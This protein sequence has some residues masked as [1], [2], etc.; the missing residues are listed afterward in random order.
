M[1]FFNVY[2]KVFP[3][4][5][6]DELTFLYFI[7]E[8]LTTFHIYTKWFHVNQINFSLMIPSLITL[9]PGVLLSSPPSFR[10]VC[11]NKQNKK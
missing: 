5:V 8:S 4:D 2:M 11:Y 6:H 1:V 9:T 7:G 10:F 3:R